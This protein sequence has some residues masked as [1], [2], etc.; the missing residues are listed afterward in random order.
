MEQAP[1]EVVDAEI[2]DSDVEDAPEVNEA[3]QTQ[4]HLGKERYCKLSGE[5]PETA[6]VHP[7]L[8]LLFSYID[9]NHPVPVKPTK[10]F[11]DISEYGLR[12]EGELYGF[13]EAFMGQVLRFEASRL[14]SCSEDVG[15]FYKLIDNESAIYRAHY[16]E[17]IK[18]SFVDEARAP[19]QARIDEFE[20]E[21][22][23]RYAQTT[24]ESFC[25]KA[26]ENILPG[27]NFT[28]D[29]LKDIFE[30]AKYDERLSKDIDAIK[31]RVNSAEYSLLKYT[32][33]NK[34]VLE[35]LRRAIV[36]LEEPLKKKKAELAEKKKE[37]EEAR[38]IVKKKGK[39]AEDEDRDRVKAI[40][41]VYVELRKSV[42]EDEK[43]LEEL[44]RKKDAIEKELKSK[45]NA[46]D[47]S[48]ADYDRLS[49][50]KQARIDRI[51]QEYDIDAPEIAKI[52]PEARKAFESAKKDFII[53][54]G[55]LTEDE[56]NE[57]M[58]LRD[59]RTDAM[60]QLL[61]DRERAKR[62]HD[63]S[64]YKYDNS[65]KCFRWLE[66]AVRVEAGKAYAAKNGTEGDHEVVGKIFR[67]VRQ[68][69]HNT[70]AR[71]DELGSD[72]YPGTEPEKEEHPEVE[73]VDEAIQNLK[74]TYFKLT[75]KEEPYGSIDE[76][77]AKFR[78]KYELW[79][80][81][82][83]GEI[84]YGVTP[85]NAKK[86]VSK[87][88]SEVRQEMREH[89]EVEAYQLAQESSAGI[90]KKIVEKVFGEEGVED[91]YFTP[92]GVFVRHSDGRCSTHVISPFSEEIKAVLTPD[93][94]DA[95]NKAWTE[96]R[97]E[98][99]E[100]GDSGFTSFMNQCFKSGVA[101][102]KESVDSE[103][104]EKLSELSGEFGFDTQNLF[105]SSRRLNHL[106]SASEI[107]AL[108]EIMPHIAKFI[109]R[110]NFNTVS[111]YGNERKI[112]LGS[113]ASNLTALIGGGKVEPFGT[114]PTDLV[115]I[116]DGRAN[117]NFYAYQMILGETKNDHE[118]ASGVLYSC[119]GYELFHNL[120]P[121]QIK[122][123]ADILGEKANVSKQTIYRNY[124]R[125][126]NSPIERRDI[127]VKT[128]FISE[129]TKFANGASEGEMKEYFENLAN[130][131]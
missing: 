72:Y 101:T 91:A 79:A 87:Y 13:D 110:V 73:T 37:S 100:H 16:A 89:I 81:Y 24:I 95:W 97:D 78:R 123:F 109:G 57:L 27:R 71:L 60:S 112:A 50:R 127:A 30:S 19:Y 105:N 6:D 32:K 86:E 52:A 46:L 48:K 23:S 45:Q 15:E 26:I 90:S 128:Y 31:A 43:E 8:E 22:N 62:S 124:G 18:K 121:R 5:D 47:S 76:D 25:Q 85:D 11:P 4:L 10:D 88:S 33:E 14:T 64:A 39:D 77:V 118:R 12:I 111:K 94:A 58:S 122:E 98:S 21:V 28:E 83:L 68:S 104:Y 38:K 125:I 65:V 119:I 108:A 41:A 42:A 99:V 113:L 96:L 131:Y 20:A 36:E 93:E 29:E 1:K 92:A 106:P 61:K 115:N 102:F 51:K 66:E 129:F 59:V 116:K 17:A 63:G 120:T 40:D 80:K 74:R 35:E 75:G 84:R 7:E 82:R 130:G 117:L 56:Y 54:N 3:F 114:R 53:E 9:I 49:A 34:Q 70:Q 126:V 103:A 69:A 107:E 67:S 2:I 44:R 55:Y